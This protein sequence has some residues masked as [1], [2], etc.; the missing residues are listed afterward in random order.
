MS[1]G[2]LT[3]SETFMNAILSHFVHFFLKERDKAVS[4]AIV[5]CQRQGLFEA[6]VEINY[7]HTSAV[8][9]S[10]GLSAGRRIKE[11]VIT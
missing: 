3:D 8:Q 1:S 7:N 11:F 9:V 5:E 4:Q 10:Q 2:I 6:I